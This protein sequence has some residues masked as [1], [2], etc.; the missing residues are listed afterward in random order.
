VARLQVALDLIA[1]EDAVALLRRIGPA[2]DVVEAGTPLIKREGMAAVAR[3]RAAVP[4]KL[5]V[6]DMKTADGGAYEAEL[7][8]GAGADLM[9]VLGC[10]S[11]ETVRATLDVARRRGR[12]VVADLLGVADKPARARQLAALG[13]DFLGVHAGTDEQASG[14]SPLAD[15]ALLR[16]TVP[17]PLVVAG[18]ISLANLAAVLVYAPAIVVVGSAI[19]RAPDPV[20]AAFAFRAALERGEGGA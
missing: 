2:V 7:A 3:L 6:A 13:V 14:A 20:V 16:G 12:Q 4:D 9:T 19:T 17:T 5:V 1:S 8:F 10:A 15:L 11:D 18:G